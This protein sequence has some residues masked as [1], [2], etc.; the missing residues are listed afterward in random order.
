M[1]FPFDPDGFEVIVFVVRLSRSGQRVETLSAV[2]GVREDLLQCDMH[3]SA[4]LETCSSTQVEKQGSIIYI[5]G[6]E[7]SSHE[8][9][10]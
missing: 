7:V 8:S 10:T 3:H 5:R 1:V 4:V 6:A 9:E 2:R